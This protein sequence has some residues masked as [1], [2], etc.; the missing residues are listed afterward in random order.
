[1][2]EMQKAFSRMEE[3]G[4]FVQAESGQLMAPSPRASVRSQ[5]R[6]AEGRRETVT[7]SLRGGLEEEGVSSG[8]QVGGRW[9]A[10]GGS[11]KWRFEER[12]RGLDGR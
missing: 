2:K 3:T 11:G 9:L 8:W 7:V 10:Q 12:G 5:L 6:P 1:M 4:T